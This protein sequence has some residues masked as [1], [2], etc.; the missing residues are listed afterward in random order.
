MFVNHWSLFKAILVLGNSYTALWKLLFFILF[1]DNFSFFYFAP[2]SREAIKC[3]GDISG[4]VAG[5]RVFGRRPKTRAASGSLYRLETR[6]RA[7]K[8]ASTQG[9]SRLACASWRWLSKVLND[10]RRGWNSIANCACPTTNLARFRG[11]S[12]GRRHFSP[13]SSA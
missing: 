4:S 12:H 13:K 6:N 2:F 8:V 7:W 11:R 1:W 9:T 5:R 10:Y 3:G